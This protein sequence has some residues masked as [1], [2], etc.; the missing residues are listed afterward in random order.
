[1][2]NEVKEK[3]GSTGKVLTTEMNPPL[4]QNQASKNDLK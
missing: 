3:K 1:M 4:E 2:M